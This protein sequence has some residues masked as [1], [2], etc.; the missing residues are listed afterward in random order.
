MKRKKIRGQNYI[1]DMTCH[2]FIDRTQPIR[3]HSV[4]ALARPNFIPE[5][6]AKARG[7]GIV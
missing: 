6:I 3:H 1:K 2:G 7:L 4:R 5:I